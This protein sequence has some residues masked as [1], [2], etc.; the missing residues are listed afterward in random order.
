MALPHAEDK[1]PVLAGAVFAGGA[2]VSVTFEALLLAF[3][4]LL[5]GVVSGAEPFGLFLS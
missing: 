2:G 1:T 4:L 5:A 3:P